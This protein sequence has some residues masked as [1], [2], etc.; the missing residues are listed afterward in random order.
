[1]IVIDACVLIAHLEMGDAHAAQALEILDTEDELAIHPMTLAECAV[2]PARLKQL[3]IFRQACDRLGLVV[4]Q[5][6]IDHPY[7]IAHLRA[8]TP[9]TLP[10]CCVLDAARAQSATLATF[11]KTLA[12]VAQALGVIVDDGSSAS[13][14][15]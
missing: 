6:D 1:M 12:K 13:V 10:D 5:P 3:T 14:A 2:G 11:D 8:T 7:R 15:N 4:W 9:L